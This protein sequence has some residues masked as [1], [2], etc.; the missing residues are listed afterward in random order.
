MK[1][2][3]LYDEVGFWTLEN[4]RD[5]IG[6]ESEITLHINSPGG[7][8]FDGI[9]IYNILKQK[10]QVN[11][12]IEGLAASISS[13]IAM[14]GNVTMMT[15]S[16]LMIHN[17]WTG[18]I[19]EAEDFAKIA[20][21]MKQIKNSIIDIYYSKT[22]IDKKKI[23]QMMDDETW[24]SVDEAIKLGFAD[25]SIEQPAIA[26]KFDLK[27][28]NFNKIP[29]EVKNMNIEN[30]TAP[31]EIE[32]TVI[33]SQE[34]SEQPEVISEQP[35]IQ[36][37]TIEEPVAQEET[38]IEA[39]EETVT[40]TKTELENL[41]KNRIQNE[42]KRIKDI[43]DLSV[44]GQEQIVNQL[45]DDGIQASDASLVL[46]TDLKNRIQSGEFSAR[47][48]NPAIAQFEDASPAPLRGTED[49]GASLSSLMASEKDPA[50][51]LQIFRNAKK[52]GHP[53][54]KK[55]LGGK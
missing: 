28:F 39:Q 35:E 5:Q 19:G 34:V 11:I 24:L 12:I 50:K 49:S 51:K 10:K 1:D 45:I 18:A 17:P 16:M 9:A 46:L 52:N 3:Y 13:V 42:H 54:L 30:E 41:I 53:E 47:K 25:S 55:A 15:G 21:T 48:E 33:E 32:E 40:M 44:E 37:E 4:I 36:P 26:A 6:E 7:S 43:K 29:T 31:A 14:A 20:E 38:A 22:G 27:K 8:V 23:S 2:V